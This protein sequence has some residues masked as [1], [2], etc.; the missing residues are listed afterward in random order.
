MRAFG[1]ARR[2][3]FDEIQ[4]RSF[5]SAKRSN[6]IVARAQLCGNA[7]VQSFRAERGIS[8]KGGGLDF[9]R[10][11]NDKREAGSLASNRVDDGGGLVGR[12]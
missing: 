9:S 5:V 10:W 1:P 6:A 3:P 8:S 12:Y 4:D 2:G 11:P 7:T